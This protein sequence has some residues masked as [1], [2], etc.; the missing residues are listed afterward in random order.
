MITNP[1]FADA[2]Q[3]ATLA[4]GTTC[5]RSDKPVDYLAAVAA[6]ESHVAAMAEKKAS[7][8]IWLLEHPAL[9]TA[10]TSAKETDLLRVDLPVF[11][12]GRG[13]QYTYHGPGQR[14]AYV[15]RDLAQ[16]HHSDLRGYVCR[17]EDWLIETL[18]PFGVTGERRTGRVGIWVDLAPYNRKGEA[19][20]AALGV[21]VRKSIA[22]HGISINLDPDLAA[23]GGIVP[24]GIRE[25]GVTSLKDLGVTADMASLDAALLEAFEKAFLPKTIHEC[26]IKK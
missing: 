18:A 8:A 1:A 25:H 23:F 10:G 6:M 21:R 16:H 19:K 14:V 26:L 17:L 11:A 4:D 13:G 24:C 5:Y 9:Y 7:G 2:K 22:Y 15:M 3:L 20:I 12:T